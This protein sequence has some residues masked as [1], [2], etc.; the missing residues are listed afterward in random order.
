[1][2]I[3]LA[4]TRAGERIAAAQQKSFANWCSAEE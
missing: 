4:A 2:L 3:D 1:V